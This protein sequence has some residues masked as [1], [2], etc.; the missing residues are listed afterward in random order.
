MKKRKLR[1]TK[2]DSYYFA[3]KISKYYLEDKYMQDKLHDELV[4]TPHDK[5]E[6]KTRF[7]SWISDCVKD[8][9]KEFNDYNGV[10]VEGAWANMQPTGKD[11]EVHTNGGNLIANY[12]IL[13]DSSHPPLRVYDPR[14]PNFYNA[15]K[16]T[17]PDG[18]TSGSQST[19]IDI[20]VEKGTLLLMPAYLLHSVPINTSDTARICWSMN[21]R[22]KRSFNAHNTLYNK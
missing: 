2:S 5:S 1:M 13:A 9:S 6:L 16:I 7:Y 12:Y 20:P 17:R 19:I 3:V 22:V 18:S 4:V 14:P 11:C 8:Y 21:L 10:E 15:Y